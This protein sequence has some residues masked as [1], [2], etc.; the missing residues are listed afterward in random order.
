MELAVLTEEE[1]KSELLDWPSAGASCFMDAMWQAQFEDDVLD[2]VR[3][4][5]E[6]GPVR[7]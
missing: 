4:R 2:R 3:G 1:A 6:A 5:L 7:I